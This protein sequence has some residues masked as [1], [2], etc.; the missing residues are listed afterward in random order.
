MKN[1][2]QQLLNW[3]LTCPINKDGKN[4]FGINGLRFD[5]LSSSQCPKAYCNH[6]VTFIL[7]SYIYFSLLHSCKMKNDN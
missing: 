2:T 5:I 1:T 6:C 7:V 3:E 4:T